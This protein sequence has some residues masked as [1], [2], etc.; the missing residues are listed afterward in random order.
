M[1][2]RG[3]PFG[4]AIMDTQGDKLLIRVVNGVVQLEKIDAGGKVQ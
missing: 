4:N 3:T 2:D 1:F